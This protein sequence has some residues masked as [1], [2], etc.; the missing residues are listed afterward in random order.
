VLA[1]SIGTGLGRDAADPKFQD[2]LAALK[3]EQTGPA[4]NPEW[5]AAVR[6]QG[7]LN[8]P[9]DAD[10]S[11]TAEIAIPFASLPAPLFNQKPGPNTAWL[12]NV[13][14]HGIG[15]GPAPA[16]EHR[17]WSVSTVL[18]PASLGAP[19]RWMPFRLDAKTVDEFAKQPQK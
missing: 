18:D 5:Q 17:T 8:T 7:S 14:V 10:T 16:P 15:N 19:S 11:W 2:E 12:A 13:I 3:L 1:D 6:V 4:W 9:G